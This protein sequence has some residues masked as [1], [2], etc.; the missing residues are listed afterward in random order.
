MDISCKHTKNN[1]IFLKAQKAQKNQRKVMFVNKRWRTGFVWWEKSPK[2]KQNKNHLVVNPAARW[3]NM[4]SVW[5]KPIKP[6]KACALPTPHLSTK[7][8]QS[9]VHLW[10]LKRYILGWKNV[11]LHKN[12]A[13]TVWLLVLTHM[14][15]IISCFYK[16]LVQILS[17]SLVELWWSGVFKL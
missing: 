2:T 3:R 16:C 6:E 13:S 1:G 11:S 12:S 15:I 4:R 17:F 8:L 7:F 10:G 5:S 14:C 9:Q